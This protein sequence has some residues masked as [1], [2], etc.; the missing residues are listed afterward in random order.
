MISDSAVTF[1]FVI[2][3]NATVMDRP[4]YLVPPSDHNL[5]V[6]LEERNYRSWKSIP[7]NSNLTK[8]DYRN[9]IIDINNE[10][11]MEDVF[12]RLDSG[13]EA[14]EKLV[15][16]C[17][18]QPKYS[19]VKDLDRMYFGEENFIVKDFI[20]WG[21]KFVR[22]RVELNEE[23]K[24]DEEMAERSKA[25]GEDLK[26]SSLECPF[27]PPDSLPPSPCLSPGWGAF[28]PS[29]LPKQQHQKDL[30]R[31][32]HMEGNHIKEERGSEASQDLKTNSLE[33]PD[34]QAAIPLAPPL[35][36]TPLKSEFSPHSHR[37]PQR[38]IMRAKKRRRSPGDLAKRRQRLISYQLSHTPPTTPRKLEPDMS[39]LESRF[40]SGSRFDSWMTP[41]SSRL[42]LGSNQET[43]FSFRKPLEHEKCLEDD[44]N[45]TN[46]YLL[47]PSPTMSL[48]PSPGWVPLPLLP[49]PC[50]PSVPAPCSPPAW[51]SS[52][53]TP[54]SP[55][56]CEGCQQWGN[57]LSVTVSQ[58]RPP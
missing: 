37:P 34:L 48:W 2:N 6:E 25:A 1:Q 27:N 46:P 54:T 5:W 43:L 20:K 3:S 9:H 15:T 16:F 23:V 51:L 13:F 8:D 21:E 14:F 32:W 33:C 47:H 19:L 35:L 26:I 57:L 39:L 41:T 38:R 4:P 18:K 53:M 30:W 10:F 22:T 40:G 31:P 11:D 45:L 56:F 49:T 36:E 52:N 44:S 29:S 50:S 28:L 58:S 24:I 42:E 55:A 17:S 7:S 12:D